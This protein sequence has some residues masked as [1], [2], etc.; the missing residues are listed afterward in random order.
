MDN[1]LTLEQKRAFYR[2]GY[3]ILKN[4]VSQDLV[5]ASLAQI[6]DGK[7]LIDDEPYKRK[8]KLEK[9][10]QTLAANKG[11]LL[12]LEDQNPA[13]FSKSKE[14][15]DLVNASS[16][17]PILQDLMGPFDP[18]T[19]CHP[20]ILPVTQPGNHFTTLGYRDKDMPYYGAGIHIDG[21]MTIN[22]PQE[23]QKGTPEEIYNRYIASGPKGDLG[24]SAEVIGDNIVPM[25][26]DPDMTLGLGSFTG[27]AIVSLSDQTVEGCG[28]TSI[29]PGAH[30]AV[31]KFFRWQR[32]TNNHIGVE[33]PGWSRLNHDVPNRCGLVYTPEAVLNQFIDESSETTPDGKHWPKPTQ[34]LMEPG[35]AC[36]KIY[37]MP[38]TGSRNELG[39]ESRKNVFFRL[40]HKKRQPDKIVNGATD[41]PDRGFMGTWLD[42]E[43]GDNPWE[44]SKYAMCNMWHE[45]DGMQAV[46]AEEERKVAGNA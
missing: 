12:S 23:V 16:L 2:D 19:L 41:H 45:W 18:P 1:K 9:Q 36:I 37:Q 10:I 14:L 39:T 4:A 33:G 25:F 21:A 22:A 29:L 7:V 38:H 40:R 46:V 13:W 44:R 43:E 3:I 28:Q 24:I 15:T 35:D 34:L 27:F 26:Q 32:D 5:E 17:T 8:E 30:H 6:N 11:K 31:E 20:A 42:Y